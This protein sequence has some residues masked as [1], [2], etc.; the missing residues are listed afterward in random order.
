[1]AYTDISDRRLVMSW[2]AIFEY[3]DC[4][5]TFEV[6]GLITGPESEMSL[7]GQNFIGDLF[8]GSDS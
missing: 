2:I 7:R 3:G 1:M 8:Y 6:R 5:L 4:E